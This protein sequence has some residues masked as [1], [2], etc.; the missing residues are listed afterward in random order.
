VCCII[1][2]ATCEDYSARIII[3]DE[4]A[5]Y[6]DGTVGD[7]TYFINHEL[8]VGRIELCVDGNWRPVCEDFW[9]SRDASVVCHQLGFSRAGNYTFF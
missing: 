2:S 9:T 8:A 4:D 3:G 5:F 1:F 6:S 7:P